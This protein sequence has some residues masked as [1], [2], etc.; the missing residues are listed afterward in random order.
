MTRSRNSDIMK[1]MKNE[2]QEIYNAASN[3]KRS[4][5]N[6]ANH[7]SK[8]V[9]KPTK[10]FIDDMLYGLM[11]SQ[12]VKLTK[13]AGSLNEE[14]KLKHTEERLRRNVNTFDDTE[15]IA[16]NYMKKVVKKC[17][18]DTVL[19]IDDGDIAKPYGSN[20]EGLSQVRDGST[21]AIVKGFPMVGMI[22][23]TDDKLPLPIYESIYSYEKDFVSANAETFKAL[24]F[25][26]KYFDKKNIR[27]FDSG[28]ITEKLM[29][30]GVNFIV[31]A[32][33]NRHVIWGGKSLSILEVAKK[34][35]GKYSLK[36]VDK[37]GK[38]RECNTWITPI[39]MNGFSLNL[40]I[41]NGVGEKP[42]MLLTNVFDDDKS[43]CNTL[44]K[45]YIMRWKIE[46]FYRFKKQTFNFEDI[47]I[48]NLKGMNTINLLLNILIGFL[49]MKS[50][51]GQ[52][53]P[54][55]VALINQVKQIYNPKNILYSVCAG[56]FIVM[57]IANTGL[58]PNI[59][60]VNNI[61]FCFFENFIGS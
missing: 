43:I 27:V 3:M 13:I 5:L 52:D 32:V 15:I 31:R 39:E 8:G 37:T 6:F 12:D 20:F 51:D 54:V 33:G 18:K 28:I 7:I 59:Q 45:C 10:N 23:L 60:P 35:K 11:V 34:F 47:R 48:M 49:S 40:V 56:L 41:C 30:T 2:R 44:V 1:D 46:E 29:N 36:Y 22:A 4:V 38:K 42:L 14:Q 19:I 53:K 9:T 50:T 24:D 25:A 17:R 26:D 16:D 61:Q 57:I 21:G 58:P 55:I